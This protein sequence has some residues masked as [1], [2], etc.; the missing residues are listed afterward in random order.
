[1]TPH[2]PAAS[3]WHTHT[4]IPVM[5]GLVLAAV[6]LLCGCGPDDLAK[7]AAKE[8]AS[9]EIAAAHARVEAAEAN[10]RYAAS[11][12]DQRARAA[13]D[14]VAAAQGALVTAKAEKRQAEKDS[15]EA[16]HEA[17]IAPLR[18]ILRTAEVLGLVGILLGVVEIVATFVWTVPIGRTLGEFMVGAG[19]AVLLLCGLLEGAL[20]HARLILALSLAPLAVWLYVWLKRTGKLVGVATAAHTTIVDAE[21]LL[22]SLGHH[23]EADALLAR[24]ALHVAV[25][26]AEG[27]A[28]ALLVKLHLAKAAMPVPAAPPITV[29]TS[30]E[31]KPVQGA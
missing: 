15:I 4:R 29:T 6:F 10:A 8:R 26:D 27:W 5:L 11:S 28:K 14:A 30:P 7:K 18:A 22:R 20:D 17:A 2:L 13:A 24:H 12:A 3:R 1:M 19:V 23:A 31:S 9:A 16:H 21:N 25:L